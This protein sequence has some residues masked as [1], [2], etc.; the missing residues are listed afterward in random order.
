MSAQ[1]SAC[2]CLALTMQAATGMNRTRSF[3]T[4][5]YES[6]WPRPDAEHS[7]RRVR[8]CTYKPAGIFYSML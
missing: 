4:P 1:F 7:V 6:Q 5:G 3:V 8:A 2:T